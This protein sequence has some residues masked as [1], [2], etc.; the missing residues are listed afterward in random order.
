M[1][2]SPSPQHDPR[3]ESD[4]TSSPNEA[5]P[6]APA[7]TTDGGL[8]LLAA[9]LGLGLHPGAWRYRSGPT[10]DYLSADHYRHLA[11]TAERGKLHGLFLAD[12]LT[13]SEDNLARPNFGA[14]DPLEA[15]SVALPFTN[16]LGLIATATTSF[17]EPYDLARRFSTLDH[18]S[19]GRAAWN[20][21]TTFIPDVAA[22]F[23]G[24]SLPAHTDRYQ[25]ANEFVDVVR[26]LWA[27]WEDGAL[28]G[29]KNGGTFA[30]S[31]L[32][33]P[34]RH[35]GDHFAVAGALTL[36]RTPQNEPVIFQAG[37][38]EDGRELAARTADAVFAVQNTI[39]SAINFRQDMRRRAV[40]HGRSPDAVKI[41]PGIVPIIAKTA[42]EAIDRKRALDELATDAELHKL[43]LRIG[44][45]EDALKL[46]EPIPF[47]L[48]PKDKEF[49]AS[50]GFRDAVLELAR[51]ENLT[52]RE[53][54]YRNGGGHPQVI[55]TP[56]D[57]ADTITTWYQSGAVDGFNLIFDVL[58]EGLEQFVDEVVPIL[59]ERGIF[60]NGYA[61][62]TFRESLRLPNTYHE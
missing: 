7:T 50:H 8:I 13:L 31:A 17:N 35:H 57:V 39:E 18:L 16:R 21:V 27:S 1:T 30:D 38:S 49:N 4:I 3:Q 36:P 32:V 42:A 52:V 9:S 59:Q 45:P 2:T 10:T 19:N 47:E 23:G 62:K 5:P 22:N 40:E 14:V 58:P 55:G 54:I 33:H 20:V 29:D 46:D 41:L 37:S 6:S 26:E 61:G 56:I 43:A 53:I 24:A 15:L 51:S 25:R 48:V 34:I 12:T 28:V 11:E 60:Q 44:V